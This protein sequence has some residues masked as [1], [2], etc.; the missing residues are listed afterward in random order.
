MDLQQFF[1]YRLARLAEAVS[2]AT[3][4]VYS[5]RFDLT[6]DEWRVLAAL[7]E[8]GAVKTAQVLES[9]T[10]DKMRVSRA[11]A[12]MEKAELVGRSSDPDDGRG[13]LVR[14]LPAGRALYRKIVPMVQAREQ[15][16]LEA[17]GPAE[18]EALD[19]AMDKVRERAL[20]LTRQG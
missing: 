9:T 20:Q 18:R 6:R 19:K 15:Y 17:L 4:Q 8:A 16:L 5:E 7:A 10:L 13:Q 3:A 2:Q 1:P 12:R 14:L 11:L